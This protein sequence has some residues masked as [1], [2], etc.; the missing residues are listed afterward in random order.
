[1]LELVNR[2]IVPEMP[3]IPTADSRMDFSIFINLL[4]ANNL[5]LDFKYAPF[6]SQ[7]N[8][9]GYE[10]ENVNITAVAS[11]DVEIDKWV[12]KDFIEIYSSN[13]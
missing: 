9:T 8:V 13:V 3:G 2:T 11:F 12:F 6:G 7:I 5:D 4:A 10:A 1:M